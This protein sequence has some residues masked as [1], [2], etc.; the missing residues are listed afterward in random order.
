[1]NDKI[2]FWQTSDWFNYN[3]SNSLQK[4]DLKLYS[5]IDTV[6]KPKKFF[7]DQKFVNYE[8]I[9]FF[10]DAIKN[11]IKCN[12]EYLQ[13]FESKYNINLWLLAINERIFYK[14]N[15][16]YEF[17]T[18][19]ILSIVE[20]ECR[21][22]ESILDEINPDYLII[23]LPWQHQGELLRQICKAK[24]IK[25]LMINTSELGGGSKKWTISQEFG[26]EDF[27][28][29]SKLNTNQKITFDELGDL[30]MK[31]ENNKGIIQFAHKEKDQSQK[32]KRIFAGLNVLTSKNTNVDTHFPYYG[33]TKTKL[34][35]Y[36]LDYD[37]YSKKR[38]SFI[39]KKFR[40]TYNKNEKIITLFLHT[41]QE[42]SLLIDA[43]FFTN[44]IEVVRHVV[45]S[46][47]IGYKLFVKE[48]P[49]MELR[50][51]RDISDYKE[52][53]EI[54][55]VTMIHPD[56]NSLEIIKDSKLVI[57]INSTAGFEALFY[58]K[59]S[60]NF[61]KRGYSEISGSFVVKELNKLP[62]LIREALQTKINPQE[63]FNYVEKIKNNLFDFNYL[64]FIKSYENLLHLNGNLVDVIIH[65]NDME[66]F[67]DI[68]KEKFDNLALEYIK[69]MKTYEQSNS[70]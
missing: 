12:F 26:Q 29:E 33:R 13:K 47:P 46:L 8:K 70:I 6:N 39:D 15:P 43:P 68:H 10:H 14:F 48:H 25:I 41:E 18:E 17:S 16:F 63:I 7:Q 32:T 38:K 65:N 40:K 50:G 24:G 61:Q 31:W 52:M 3:L 69:K 51:W 9:W 60:I 56:V 5:I 2:L 11:K 42:R 35:K 55:N 54:P 20:Q 66:K 30:L 49:T 28:I 57:S 44:Q 45:K 36:E 59:P 4:Y 34:I 53:M 64:E 27:P 1:M 19:E 67:L 23:S 62:D 22:F 21:F 37:K 58:N